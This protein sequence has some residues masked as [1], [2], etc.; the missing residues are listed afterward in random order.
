[1]SPVMFFEVK[2]FELAI[3]LSRFVKDFLFLYYG[4]RQMSHN[5]KPPYIAQCSESLLIHS[6]LQVF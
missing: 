6:S 1:M 2:L 5:N 4:V 3:A